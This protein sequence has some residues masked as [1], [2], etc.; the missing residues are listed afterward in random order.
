MNQRD[1]I[2]TNSSDFD[3]ERCLEFSRSTANTLL[4]IKVGLDAVGIIA[5]LTVVIIVCILRNY[6]RFMYRLVIY[7]V[8]ANILQALFQIL[9]LIP[10]QVMSED[11]QVSVREGTGWFSACQTLGYLDLVTFW[12]ENLIIIWIML[13]MVWRLQRLQKGRYQDTEADVKQIRNS[14]RWE[15][16]GIITVLFSSFL[17]SGIPFIFNMYGLSGLWCWIKIVGKNGCTANTNLARDSLILSLFMSYGPLLIVTIFS[18]VS[19]I[20]ICAFF[21]RRRKYLLL[22]TQCNFVTIAIR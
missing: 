16:A 9:G 14:R 22:K 5:S 18:L 17:V 8:A 13:A 3:S 7:L 10:V 15:F 6:K 20:V 11:D 4:G 21:V 12:M 19:M 1:N 2:T